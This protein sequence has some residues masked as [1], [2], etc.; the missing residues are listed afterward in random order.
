[1]GIRDW[2][3]RRPTLDLTI[4]QFAQRVID[5]ARAN[6]FTGKARIVPGTQQIRFRDPVDR[7]KV[8]VLYLGNA[9]DDYVAAEFEARPGVIAR[10]LALGN[11]TPITD[12]ASRILPKATPS[13]DVE[14][15]VLNVLPM[16]LNGVLA[17]RRI[18]PT[19]A[20]ELAVDEP[21]QVRLITENDLA[22]AGLTEAEAFDHAI[23]NLAA[24]SVGTWKEL[25]PGLLR[26]PWADYF[27]GARLAIPDLFRRLGVRGDPI[28]VAPNRNTVLVTGSQELAGLR[29]LH[30]VATELMHEDRTLDLTPLRLAGDQWRPISDPDLEMVQQAPSLLFLSSVQSALDWELLLDQLEPVVRARGLVLVRPET[31]RGPP[32]MTSAELPTCSGLALPQV[33]LLTF[34]HEGNPTAIA[35]FKAALL[36]G[37]D[38]V[39]LDDV[40]PPMYEVRRGIRPEEITALRVLEARGLL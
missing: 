28:V 11:M 16:K 3:R 37:P 12:L 22:Q 27:D 6:G 30:G 40:F 19:L 7:D 29:A 24:R 4:E 9:Y 35:W 21:K 1:M 33:D 8:F 26:S 20:L 25:R 10:Y 39:L 13:R 18:G 14:A 38:L 23:A 36:L 15:R 31:L 34:V 5:A 2:F 32:L 17:G